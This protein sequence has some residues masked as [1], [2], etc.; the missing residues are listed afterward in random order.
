MF[1]VWQSFLSLD[2]GKEDNVMYK[3]E[4]KLGIFTLKMPTQF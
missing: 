2:Y 4:P 3:L 1:H